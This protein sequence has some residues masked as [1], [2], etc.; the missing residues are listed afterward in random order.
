MAQN[1]LS[2][3]TATALQSFPFPEGKIDVDTTQDWQALSLHANQ[4]AESRMVI[5]RKTL[6]QPNW[7]IT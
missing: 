1:P 6:T 4:R 7:P 5:F 2:F 3:Q